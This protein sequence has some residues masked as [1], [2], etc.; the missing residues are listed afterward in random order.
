MSSEPKRA[1]EPNPKAPHA[2]DDKRGEVDKESDR[3]F[4]SEAGKGKD[5]EDDDDSDDDDKARSSNPGALDGQRR[6]VQSRR[7]H[8]RRYGHGVRSHAAIIPSGTS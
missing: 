7:V 5:D 3:F 6:A 2:D 4:D 8:V 1:S